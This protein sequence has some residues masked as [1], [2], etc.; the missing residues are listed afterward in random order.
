M[1]IVILVL[2][3]N[4]VALALL[5]HVGR[6]YLSWKKSSLEVE[7]EYEVDSV[8]SEVE[9]GLFALDCLVLILIVGRCCRV[10]SACA[11]DENV[12][13]AELSENCLVSRLK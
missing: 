5:Y 2:A 12:T 8:L 6:K 13:F 1:L 9:E 10:V 11:V 7:L 3:L 4:G